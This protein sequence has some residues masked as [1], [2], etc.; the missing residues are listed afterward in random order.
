MFYRSDH[1]CLEVSG[2]SPDLWMLVYR[3]AGVWDRSQ[4]GLSR[5]VSV[6]YI[7]KRSL[8]ID[9]TSTSPRSKS[10]CTIPR[11]WVPM[12]VGRVPSNDRGGRPC[13][14]WNSIAAL[15]GVECNR[16]PLI[17]WTG[18]A[19]KAQQ[20]VLGMK[21]HIMI[22]N[23]GWANQEVFTA[24]VASVLSLDTMEALF[25]YP[26]SAPL[27]KSVSNLFQI[28]HPVT[29]LVPLCWVVPLLLCVKSLIVFFPEEEMFRCIF[30]ETMEGA[31]RTRSFCCKG[32]IDSIASEVELDLTNRH[33]ECSWAGMG[34]E[35]ILCHFDFEK[36]HL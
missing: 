31:S 4:I 18:G 27:V 15:Q 22:S 26:I 21:S 14:P 16:A 34:I 10:S 23:L 13:H 29:L 1:P 24:F 32:R 17:I 20:I 8:N 36:L 19:A 33:A 2:Q 7:L 30:C 12:A 35:K 9:R 25:R 11:R 5:H 28:S 6:R 3:L